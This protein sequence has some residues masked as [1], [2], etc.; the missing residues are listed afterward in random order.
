MD[1]HKEVQELHAMQ[2]AKIYTAPMKRR[3]LSTVQ[4]KKKSVYVYVATS[5]VDAI[6]D[7]IQKADSGTYCIVYDVHL[8]KIADIVQ[9]K[10][11]CAAIAVPCEESSKSFEQVKR[12]CEDFRLKHVT[13]QT[14]LILIGGSTLI[15][16]GVFSANVF[17]EQPKYIC[18]PTTLT[19]MYSIAPEYTVHINHQFVKN[20]YTCTAVPSAIVY[21]LHVL[22]TLPTTHV[23]GGLLEAVRISALYHAE[24]F[25]WI[26]E[27]MDRLMHKELPVLQTSVEK[28]MHVQSDIL[29][30]R[31]TCTTFSHT[32]G[33]ALES[34]SHCSIPYAHAM[35]IGMYT[36]LLASKSKA[37]PRIHALIKKLQLPL[38][39]PL[40]IRSQQIW[41]LIHHVLDSKATAATLCTP[42]DIGS[43]HMTTIHFADLLEVRE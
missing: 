11:Q 40:E 38:H 9:K 35:S 34:L 41:E 28:I 16:L 13:K 23:Y 36:E 17:H 6:V 8:K 42:I 25:D 39:I 2:T 33:T 21:D 31:A 4:H 27:N 20:M 30:G 18:V 7:Y 10:L 14:T 37:L 1:P 3:T 19:A 22:E 43:P 15:D 32:I 5:Y 29:L 24:L 12:I 26:E